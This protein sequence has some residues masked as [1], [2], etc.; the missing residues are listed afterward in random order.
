MV[1]TR[2]PAIGTLTEQKSLG[3]GGIRKGGGLMG[4]GK[5]LKSDHI[6]IKNTF[7]TL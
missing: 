2:E 5:Y 3:W 7:L 6:Y 4:K 1:M